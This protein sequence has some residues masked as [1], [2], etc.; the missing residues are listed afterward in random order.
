MNKAQLFFYF[1]PTVFAFCLPFGG[2][3]LSYI[4]IAWLFFSLFNIKYQKLKQGI[5]SKAL[6]VSFCFFVLTLLSSIIKGGQ[7]ASSS[8]EVKLSFAIFPFLFFCFD[9]PIVIIKRVLMAFV[10]GSFFACLFL[11][12]RGIY[13]AI[14]NK[15][16]YLVYTNFSYFIHTAY[17]SM[18]LCVAI[19]ILIIYYPIWFKNSLPLLKFS[20]LMLLVFVICI[21]LCSSKIGIVSLLFCAVCLFIN[22]Y[23]NRLTYLRMILFAIGFTLSLIVIVKFVPSVSERFNNLVSLNLSHLNKQSTESS[24][25]RVLIWQQCITIIKNNWLLGVGVGNANPALMASYKANGLTGAYSHNLNAHNQFFQTT[26]GLGFVGLS[27]LLILI[28]MGIIKTI[29]TNFILFVTSLILLFNFLTESMLQTAA[30]VLF[31]CF[32]TNLFF[33]YTTKKLNEKMD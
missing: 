21:F 26:I 8:I 30:G 14:N 27:L 3:I 33:N 15:P 16:E 28:F 2:F 22:K 13:F 7:E 5:K 25:V 20:K 29:K 19:L 24:E 10:S 4:V 31:F 9:Y 18:Y 23:K 32:F 11:L 6:I 1:L 12:I 17:F